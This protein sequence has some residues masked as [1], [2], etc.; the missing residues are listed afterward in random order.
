M[1]RKNKIPHCRIQ[2][3]SKRRI[4]KSDVTSPTAATESVLVTAEIDATEGRDVSVIDAP[5][6]FLTSDMD[7]EVIVV[8]ENEM[9]GAILEID[10]D[11]YRK[12]VIH[13]K[14]GEK[15][16][17]VRLSKAMYGTLKASLLYY[18]KISK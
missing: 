6:A 3:K 15:H 8:L 1:M 7:E 18:R 10:R 4:K 2:T 17:Y 16:M 11:V 13:G 9:A 14:N 5:G 12:C